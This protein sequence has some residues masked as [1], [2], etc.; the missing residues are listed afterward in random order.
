MNLRRF[1]QFQMGALNAT[2]LN[3]MLDAIARLQQR[4]DMMP[5]F[6]EP[7]RETILVRITGS[8]TRLRTEG[9][10]GGDGVSAVSYPFGEVTVNIKPDGNITGASCMS[11]EFVEGGIDNERGA[12]LLALEEVP[13]LDSGQVVIAHHCA[14]AVTFANESRQMVYVASTGGK[15]AVDTYTIIAEAGLG[16]YQAVLIGGSGSGSILIENLYETSNYYSALAG[17]QN[18]CAVLDPR[19]LIP[20]DVVF[21]FKIGSKTYTCAPTAFTVTCQPCGTASQGIAALNDA[22][23]AASAVASRMLGG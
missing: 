4:M 12:V 20:G 10:E 16:R 5:A 6:M 23:G 19:K 9:C 1:E 13:S 14:G 7:T 21:G 2:R 22:V 8:G 17:P 18:P 11:Y 3:E 15:P